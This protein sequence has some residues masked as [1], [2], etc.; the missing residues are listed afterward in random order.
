MKQTMLFS[1]LLLTSITA[2]AGRSTA[3]HQD[4]EAQEKSPRNPRTCFM[5]LVAIFSYLV[6]NADHAHPHS[7][8][9]AYAPESR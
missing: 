7:H 5:I 3:N 9:S 1:L 4:I 2:Y 8:T 6:H